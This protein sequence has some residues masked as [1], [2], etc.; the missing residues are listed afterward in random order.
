MGGLTARIGQA[1]HMA[2]ADAGPHA[3][4][5]GIANIRLKA[6]IVHSSFELHAWADVL[7]R[8]PRPPPSRKGGR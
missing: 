4:G 5:A 6:R 3:M 1:R 2:D 8:E 7:G